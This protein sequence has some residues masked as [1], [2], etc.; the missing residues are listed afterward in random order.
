M[1]QRFS[2]TP[3]NAALYANDDVVRDQLTEGNLVAQGYFTARIDMM[4]KSENNADLLHAFMLKWW[5][6]FKAGFETRAFGQDANK[7]D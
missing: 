4:L 6:S 5:P 1:S 2:T 3:E 7:E